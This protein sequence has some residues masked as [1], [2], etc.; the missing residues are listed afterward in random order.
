LCHGMSIDTYNMLI[1]TFVDSG[2]VS[3]Q[4]HLLKWIGKPE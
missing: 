4:F 1:Q 3:N 2:K